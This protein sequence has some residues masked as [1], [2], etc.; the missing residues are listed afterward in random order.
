MSDNESRVSRALVPSST[1]SEKTNDL[2]SGDQP[3]LLHGNHAGRA[4][5][6][7]RRSAPPRAG[8]T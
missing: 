1:D 5:V 3:I 8:S 4:A 7:T 6:Y 2:P